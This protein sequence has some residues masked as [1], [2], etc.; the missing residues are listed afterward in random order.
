MLPPALFVTYLLYFL[1][2]ISQNNCHISSQLALL[3]TQKGD[4]AT[5]KLM[6]IS[7][8]TVHKSPS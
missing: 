2:Q 7:F 3:S 1:N 6:N 8:K 5:E 4:V